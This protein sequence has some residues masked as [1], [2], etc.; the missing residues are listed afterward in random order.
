MLLFGMYNKLGG[1]VWLIFKL[2][3]D[4][5]WFGIKGLNNVYNNNIYI[6]L[7]LNEIYFWENIF[8]FLFFMYIF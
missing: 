7:V 2:E 4:Q 5:I 8:E 1:K 6:E 3:V